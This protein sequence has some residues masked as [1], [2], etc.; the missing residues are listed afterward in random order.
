[1]A[2]MVFSDS[3][4]MKTTNVRHCIQLPTT[5]SYTLLTALVTVKLVVSIILCA[6]A[7]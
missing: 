6:A 3:S 4:G 2:G 5:A 1:M 7:G